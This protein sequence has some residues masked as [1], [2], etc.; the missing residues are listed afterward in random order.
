MQSRSSSREIV[1]K[2]CCRGGKIVWP[3]RRASPE[4]LQQ[5]VRFDGDSRSNKFM[6]LIRQYNSLFAFTSLGVDVDKSINTGGGPYVF[7]ING[8]VHHRIGSLVPPPGKR[9]EYAQ[10]Y[11]HDTDNEIQ[12]RLN[13]FSSEGDGDPDPQ[14]FRMARD[15]M[16][17]PDTPDIAIKLC[18]A[19]DGHG[20]I[21]CAPSSSELA[22]LLIGGPSPEVSSFDI[23]V[24]TQASRLKPVSPIHPTLMALQYPLLFPYGEPGFH[25]SIKFAESADPVGDRDEVSMYEYYGAD[26]HYRPGQPNPALCSG[27]AAVRNLPGYIRCHWPWRFYGRD[28]GVKKTLPA[29]HIGGKRYMQQNYHDCLV[30]CCTYGPPH[31]F[32]TFTCNPK[33]PEIAEAIR[34]EPGQKPS[35]RADM[36]VRVF[37]MK[38][39]EYLTD[40][41]EGRV[42]GP[43]RAVAHTNEFQKRGLPHSHILV[44]QSDTGREQTAEDVDKYISAELPDPK[45]DPLAF[46]LVQEFMIHGPCGN[47]NPSSQCM[48]DGKCSKRYPK[49]FRSETTFD[50]DGYPLYRRRDNG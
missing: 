3:Q 18:G 24:E 48:K 6:R 7:R 35:D 45:V 15:R 49:K 33:W 42:F 10:L 41:K 1:Y 13:I 27:L 11:I 22:A 46:S 17:S 50:Q 19:V 29:S 26:M 43:V 36:V 40:I 32:T 44:W 23:V 20:D 16:L 5:L 9:P 31:K 21:Y 39:E 4:L 8:V 28:V 30:I 38:L 14:I 25:T 47:A 37:H 2:G 12:N 34:C